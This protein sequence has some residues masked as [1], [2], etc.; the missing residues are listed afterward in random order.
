MKAKAIR[1]PD[2]LLDAVKF[3]EKRERLDEPT[4]LQ[5]FLRLGAEKYIA[6]LYAR[7]EVSLREAADVLGLP[8]REAL[9]LFWEMGISGNVG[10]SETLKS[11]LLTEESAGDRPAVK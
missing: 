8:V 7:G 10:A 3:A 1:L 5:K 4:T 2:D 6:G 9:D 11:I